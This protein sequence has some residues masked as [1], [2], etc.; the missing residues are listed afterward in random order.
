VYRRLRRW[1]E[2]QALRQVLTELANAQREQG[3]VD[4]TLASARGRGAAIGR[5][6]RGNRVKVMAIV[7]RSGDRR[8]RQER[9]PPTVMKSRSCS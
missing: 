7:D 9:V 6:R 5:T 2:G 1:C 8:F 3:C 4:A